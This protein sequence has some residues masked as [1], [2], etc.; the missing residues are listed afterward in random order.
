MCPVKT[1]NRPNRL[2]DSYRLRLMEA[3]ITQE[4]VALASPGHHP[5]GREVTIQFVNRVLNGKQACPDWLRGEI[6][7]L[8]AEADEG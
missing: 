8:L 5:E 7:E 4:A 1:E 6:D 3:G 2:P